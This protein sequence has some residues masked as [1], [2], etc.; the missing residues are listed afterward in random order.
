MR[1][2]V[3]GTTSDRC[4]S[5]ELRCS[6][7][8]VQS[9]SEQLSICC[10]NTFVAPPARCD[11]LARVPG[12]YR[13]APPAELQWPEHHRH[14]DCTSAFDQAE[15]LPSH[16]WQHPPRSWAGRARQRR[17]AEDAPHAWPLATPTP[18]PG[19]LQ[20]HG[21][22]VVLAAV[23]GLAGCGCDGPG[24]RAERKTMQTT[25]LPAGRVAV[26]GW[27]RGGLRSCAAMGRT[28]RVRN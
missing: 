6:T 8:N 28:S 18:L 27:W 16:D 15:P 3:A 14:V 1:D 10:C 17:V 22:V 7:T 19:G 21:G 12:A 9:A 26:R 20:R 5:V 13:H 11:R 2:L 25:L 24:T 4:C 23:G